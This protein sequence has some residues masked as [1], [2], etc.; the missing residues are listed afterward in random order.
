VTDD[1]TRLIHGALMPGVSASEPE[2]WVGEALA[3]GVETVCLFGEAVGSPEITRRTTSALR[4]LSPDLIISLDEE[5]G[6]VTRVE[7]L[8]GSSFLA[9]LALG[10]IDDVDVTR[11][12]ARLVG[13]LLRDV[14]VDWTLA[15]VADVNVDPANPVI[16][17]RS[18]GSDAAGVAEHAAA[19]IEGLQAQGVLACAKH[20][21]GHGDT[22]VDSHEALP[23]LA[24]EPET[25]DER[26]LA[27]FR[28]AIAAGVA[29][30]MTG[31]LLVPSLDPQSAASASAAI[32]TGLLREQLG[33][34]GV[35]ITDAIE[36]AA[37][38]GPDRSGIG[39]AAVSALLAGADVVC[40]GAA[41]QEAALGT[42]VEAIRAAVADGRLGQDVLRAAADRRQRM[43]ASRRASA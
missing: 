26:E 8:R 7:A 35:V 23:V 36:M 6:D 17:V 43:R 32:T 16:G 40:I 3:S 19:F 37:V 2:P 38:S 39:P 13:R 20:F 5:S 33:Y 28:A 34:E 14:G 30:I 24:V 25:L 29:S 42:C 15:P 18:F 27:P 41:D 22:S 12:S 31:H 21:P 4:T 10:A 9:P 11:A 1:L